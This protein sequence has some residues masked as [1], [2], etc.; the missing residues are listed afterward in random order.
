MRTYTRRQTAELLQISER[1]LDRYI[2]AG[3]LKVSKAGNTRTS[4]VFI[5]DTALDR[6]L[7]T[8]TKTF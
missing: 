3:K 6:F 5:T 2:K 1:T 4:R 8:N 7:K